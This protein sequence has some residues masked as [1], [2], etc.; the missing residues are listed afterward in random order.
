[1]SGPTSARLTRTARRVRNL[2][3]HLGRVADEERIRSVATTY[4]RLDYPAAEIHLQLSSRQEFARLRSCYKEPWTVGWIE[5][6]V[7]PGD[8]LYDVG[9][10]VGAYTLVAA[11]GVPGARVVAFEPSP[12]N[13]AALCANVELNAVAGS[14]IA[15]PLALGDRARWERLGGDSAVPGAAPSLGAGASSDATTVLV[16][17]LDDVVER[18]GLPAPDH[19]K[20]DVE[21][22]E[23]EVLLGAGRQLGSGRLRSAMVELDHD[24]EHDVVACLEGFG[25]ALVERSTRAGSG[26]S[27][28]AYGLFERR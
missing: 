14:V 4:G 26:A 21:G 9:A 1:V 3:A 19:L 8:V 5:R 10:N 17:T 27:V 23:L 13:F 22:A 24:R 2:A 18:Y 7:K 6:C 12:A 20:I 28:P 15:V 25:Y 11:V 16:D